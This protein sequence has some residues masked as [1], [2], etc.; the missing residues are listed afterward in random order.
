MLPEKIQVA[1]L[2]ELRDQ[3]Q[4][5]VSNQVMQAREKS[6]I[7]FLAESPKRDQAWPNQFC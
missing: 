1:Q 7:I 4:V 5:S 3:I 2:E 6:V